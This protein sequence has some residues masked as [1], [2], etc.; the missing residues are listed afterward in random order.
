MSEYVGARVLS[1]SSDYMISKYTFNINFNRKG[2]GIFTELLIGHKPFS[3]YLNTDLRRHAI[4]GKMEL[5]PGEY[6]NNS[7]KD[8]YRVRQ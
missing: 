8:L 3:S 1:T 5:C 4:Y 6:D 7:T 2:I